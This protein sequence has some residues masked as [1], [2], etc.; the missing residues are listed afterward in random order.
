MADR[1]L[2]SGRRSMGGKKE[3]VLEKHPFEDFVSDD[4]ETLIVGT[5]PTHLRNREYEFYYAGRTSHFWSIIQEVFSTNF[6]KLKGQS[7]IAERMSFAKKYKIGF[8]D[9]L[10]ECYRYNNRSSDANLYPVRLK[11]LDSL[12]LKYPSIKSIVFTS[13]TDAVG[14]LGIF[15]TYLRLNDKP[16]LEMDTHKGL[17]ESNYYI[18]NRSLEIMVPYSPAKRSVEKKGLKR[19]TNIYGYILNGFEM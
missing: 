12:L 11:D 8:T 15:Q 14:A 18:N 2:L 9:M 19:V 16:K 6:Q 10:E 13:R 4:T 5:F 7:A 1:W 3:Y 17:L